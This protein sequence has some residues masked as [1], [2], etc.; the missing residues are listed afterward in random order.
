MTSDCRESGC[1]ASRKSQDYGDGDEEDD[2]EEEELE[3]PRVCQ[4]DDCFYHM[5]V[6]NRWSSGE[7]R[8]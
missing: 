8:I 6:G 3:G 7:T 2:G 1:E 5:K 4:L